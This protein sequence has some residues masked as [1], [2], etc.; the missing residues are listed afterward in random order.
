MVKPASYVTPLIPFVFTTLAFAFTIMSITSRDW[1]SQK[2]YDPSLDMKDWKSPLYSIYRSPFK[3]CVMNKD[4]SVTNTTT[5]TLQCNSFHPYGFDKTSCETVFATQNYSAANTGDERLCQQIHSA[6]NLAITSTTFIGVGFLLTL[7]MTIMAYV[8]VASP[9]SQANAN[10]DTSNDLEN[11]DGATATAASTRPSYTQ[12]INLVLILCLSIG[13]ICGLLAQ[14]YG[15]LGFVQSQPDNG[16]FASGRGNVF[17]PTQDNAHMPWIEGTVL[18]SYLTCAWVFSA[19]AAGAAAA[20][21]SL[22]CPPK[23]I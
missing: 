3:I 23:D 19:F 2:H 13:G 20:V 16:A 1:A 5:Y 6:G 18:R 8:F 15:I 21:W 10:V 22:P 9:N 11:R 17:D 4:V 7:I 12:Y 14:F